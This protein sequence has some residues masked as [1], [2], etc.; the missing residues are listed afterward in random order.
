MGSIQVFLIVIICFFLTSLFKYNDAL[1][2]IDLYLLCTL[3]FSAY[4]GSKMGVL[5]A[6]LCT[7]VRFLTETY[8]RTGLAVLMDMKV[9]IWIAQIFIVAL[10]VGYVRDTLMQT[11]RDI[12]L[13][14]DYLNDRLENINSINDSNVKI[15][16]FFEERVV[17]SNESVGYI[18]NII[19]ILD[20]A[21]QNEVLFEATRILIQMLETES[22]SIY[23]VLNNGYLRIVSSTNERSRSL[24][25]S[26]RK[27]SL[28]IVFDQLETKK[29]Y[30]NR[31]LDSD[32]PDMIGC[33][34]DVDDNISFIVMLWDVKYDHMTLYYLNLLQ[35]ICKLISN[36]VARSVEFLEVT[37]NSRLI[38]N[39]NILNEN[40]FNELLDLYKKAS[41]NH[42]TEYCLINVD[43]NGRSPLQMNDTVKDAIRFTDSMGM[44]GEETLQILLT[45]TNVFDSRIV[46]KRLKD[47]GLDASVAL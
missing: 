29:S 40:A 5:S 21:K 27:D 25:K 23:Q 32:L 45:N 43:T 34:V 2:S 6:S 36:A 7:L 19:Q 16:D 10:A 8:N 9:Y 31:L 35:V 24:G 11:K 42:L 44:H 47:K 20:N 30:V 39:T 12:K 15:K 22:V 37:K 41:D 14:T 26:I 4:Y 17:D 46:I 1:S 33:L 13:E 28:P 3:L 38:E 18:Y